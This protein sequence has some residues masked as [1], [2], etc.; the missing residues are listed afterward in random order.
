MTSKKKKG[1]K[2]FVHLWGWTNL[3]VAL[4]VLSVKALFVGVLMKDNHE[5]KQIFSNIDTLVLIGNGFDVWQGLKTKYSHFKEYYL[6]HQNEILQKLNLESLNVEGEDEKYS[7]SDAELIY[8]GPFSAQELDDDF[9]NTFESSLGKIDCEEINMYFGKEDEDLEEL[10]QSVTS[11]KEILTTAFCDWICSIK[12]PIEKPKFEF[13]N[14]CLFFNFNYTDTLVSRFNVNP[15]NI[16]YVHGVVEQPDSIIVGHSIHP[17]SPEPALEEW[18][19]RFKGLFN[20]ENILYQTD[21]HVQTNIQFI[22]AQLIANGLNLG[23]I[24]NVFVLGHS[25]GKEDF[26]YFDFIKQLTSTDKIKHKERIKRYNVDSISEK[27][28][29]V[30]YIVQKIGYSNENVDEEYEQAIQR[31]YKLEQSIINACIRKIWYK[32]FGIS[33]KDIRTFYKSKGTRTQSVKWHMSS[34][35][36]KDRTNIK[37]VMKSICVSSSD[38]KTYRSIDACIAQNKNV[39]LND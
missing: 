35:S 29:R 4:T 9:W 2:G 19:G 8:G 21:K 30:E 10:R 5:N 15:H 27:F 38:Y 22:K 31:K 34:F 39:L 13:G 37:K 28:K 18:G 20:V 17:F 6:A 1:C 3:K 24:K 16:F 12:I 25:F 36:D 14:N 33:K 26:D 32:H 11:A 7:I 23:K